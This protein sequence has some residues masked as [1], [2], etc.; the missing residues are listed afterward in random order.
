M[1]RE[2]SDRG[3]SKGVDLGVCHGE[4]VRELDWG[5]CGCEHAIGTGG[6]PGSRIGPCGPGGIKGVG[7]LLVMS[8]LEARWGTQRERSKPAPASM[9]T[10]GLF[11]MA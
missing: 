3:V 6:V 9:S 10:P 8:E 5:V 2:A 7:S 11:K 1:C 4:L